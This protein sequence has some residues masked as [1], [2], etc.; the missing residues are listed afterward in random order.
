MIITLN[1]IMYVFCKHIIIQPNAI[2][3]SI[4]LSK[5]SISCQRIIHFLLFNN[6]CR[7]VQMLCFML[8]INPFY[9]V[10]LRCWCTPMREQLLQNY[11]A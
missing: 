3:L 2:N 10:T 1:K 5:C 11:K 4:D 8:E 7:L 9:V 6:Q